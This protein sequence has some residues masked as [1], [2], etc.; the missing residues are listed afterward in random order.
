MRWKES[1]SGLYRTKCGFLWKP[2]LL[3]GE[4]R[5]LEFAVWIEEYNTTYHDWQPA[6]W[7]TIK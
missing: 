6:H 4:Y 1:E 3:D 7:K 5:W 2:I